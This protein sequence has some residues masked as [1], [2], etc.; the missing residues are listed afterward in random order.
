MDT[1]AHHHVGLFYL[2]ILPTVD[3]GKIC[4]A[5]LGVLLILECHLIVYFVVIILQSYL[6]LWALYTKHTTLT[7]FNDYI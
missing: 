6:I 3:I 4:H 7:Y 1:R 5:L 2:Y